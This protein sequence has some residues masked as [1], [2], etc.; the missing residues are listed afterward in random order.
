MARR[1]QRHKKL[2]LVF[3]FLL[4]LLLL[5]LIFS[6]FPCKYCQEGFSA[7]SAKGLK[8]HQKKC[9]AHLN[10][11][12]AANKRRKAT[13]TS[14]N[15]RRTKLKERKERLGSLTAAAPGPGVSFCDF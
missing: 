3:V 1:P 10:H 4:P 7:V 6:M 2:G 14:K 12:A 9:Q 8:Q 13:V 15:I 5:L 11:E